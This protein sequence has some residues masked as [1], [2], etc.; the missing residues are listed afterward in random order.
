[1]ATKKSVNLNND[2]IVYWKSVS[3]MFFYATNS[4]VSNR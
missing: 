1:M 2:I 4:P 3:L